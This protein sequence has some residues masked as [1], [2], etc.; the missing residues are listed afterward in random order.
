MAKLITRTWTTRGLNGRKVRR[1]AH[2]YQLM[3]AGQRERRVSE[4]WSRDDALA[5]LAVESIDGIKG[6][7]T[8]RP[9]SALLPSRTLGRF[10]P[11]HS[12][13]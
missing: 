10:R 12:I 3:L 1:T 4:D 2:G 13:P 7:L 6:V 11:W 8:E 5:A 9:F